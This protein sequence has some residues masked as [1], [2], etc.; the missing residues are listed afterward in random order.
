MNSNGY[1]SEPFHTITYERELKNLLS[2]SR[3]EE[4]ENQVEI[5]K[6]NLSELAQYRLSIDEQGWQRLGTDGEE[7][8]F[9]YEDVKKARSLAR[10]MY[11]QNPM[12]RRSVEVQKLYVWALGYKIEAADPNVKLLLDGFV[13]DAKNVCE[14][15]LEALAQHEVTLQ[16]NGDKYFMYF[17]D[18]DTGRVRIRS[19]D[20]DQITNIYRNPDDQREVWY[21][22][23]TFVVNNKTKHV[24]HRDWEYRPLGMGVDPRDNKNDPNEDIND[25]IPMSQIKVGGLDSMKFGFPEIHPI[26]NWALAYK[27][28]LENWSTMMESYAVVAMQ[29]IKQS[30][31]GVAA[32]KDKLG[33]NPTNGLIGDANP[34]PGVG[35]WAAMAGGGKL[36]AVRTAGATT[37][38]KEGHPLALMIAAGAGIPITFYGEADVGNMA[39]AATLDRPTELKMVFRQTQWAIWLSKIFKFVILQSALAKGGLMRT[40]GVTVKMFPDKVEGC[41]V[42]QI[43]YPSGMDPKF[44]I[45]FP[46]ITEPNATERVRA[47]VM[48]VTMM[49]KPVT[50]IFPDTR[51]VA[52]LVAKALGLKNPEAI[53]EMCYP[54]GQDVPEIQDINPEP[55]TGLGP[56]GQPEGEE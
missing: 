10:L 52:L 19:V 2:K 24:W 31:A 20:C 48:A 46:D 7:W 43:S 40:V 16:V 30:K 55:T 25:E 36:E 13:E 29:L 28:F 12:V 41:Y 34:P 42:P 6:E 54:A 15:G 44:S 21:Y 27:K 49:G 23:R 22:R 26:L 35:S 50:S 9:S 53:V 17:I 5:L 11:L 33:S 56:G 32:A 4:L 45:E 18:R 47:V 38:A 39:T 51:L 14:M 1:L 3:V 8:D 37:A